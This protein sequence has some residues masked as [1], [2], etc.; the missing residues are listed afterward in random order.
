[1]RK[2]CEQ[3]AKWQAGF[4][5][6]AIGHPR[7]SVP[8][9]GALGLHLCDEHK[10]NPQPIREFFTDDS[11]RQ[12]NAVFDKIGKARADFRGGEWLFTPIVEH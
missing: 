9:E 3:V 10:A 12:M 2:D 1:M 7:T 6:W 4:R 11:I 8:V 5:A